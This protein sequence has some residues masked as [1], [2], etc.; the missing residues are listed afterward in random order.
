MKID[1]LKISECMFLIDIVREDKKR[2]CQY[3]D[4]QDVIDEYDSIIRKLKN[5]IDDHHGTINALRAITN[6]K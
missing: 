6:S 3:G 1:T 5:R 4:D 2:W